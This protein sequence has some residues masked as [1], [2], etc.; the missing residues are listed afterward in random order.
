MRRFFFLF[1]LCGILFSSEIARSAFEL[2]PL[3]TR[4]L[5]LGLSRFAPTPTCLFSQ[6]AL[7]TKTPRSFQAD[8][9]RLYDLAELSQGVVAANLP[10]GDFAFGLGVS[11]FGRS[12]YY[13]ENQVA[14]G[15]ARRVNNFSLGA[16][17]KFWQ[18]ALPAPYSSPTG[19]AADLG[20]TYDLS[21]LG[22][23][24]SSLGNLS[25]VASDD[26]LYPPVE[27]A[28]GFSS[29]IANQFFVTLSG[30]WDDET[31]TS[32]RFGQEYHVNSNLTLRFGFLTDPARFTLGLGVGKGKLHID[33]GF[34][35]HPV[36][37][38]SHSVGVGVEW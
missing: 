6:P 30:Q 38:G 14:F 19:I 11:S 1:S 2:Q 7:L 12:D 33:Y 9:F 3:S 8:Y 21:T 18:V 24:G 16:G 23:F 20:L 26:H 34:L 32:L 25:L 27:I 28:L 10:R 17:A 35:S 31:K 15:V 13:R 37:S 29:T 22:R 36:F 5:A 4:A